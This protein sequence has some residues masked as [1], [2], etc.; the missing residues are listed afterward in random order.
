MRCFGCCTSLPTERPASSSRPLA[1]KL[2]STLRFAPGVGVCSSGACG[3]R[4]VWR[5]RKPLPCALRSSATPA[6][7]GRATDLE[8]HL[9][10]PGLC[11]SLRW[12][13]SF[14]WV[15]FLFLLVRSLLVV[16]LQL[17]FLY[18]PIFSQVPFP[19]AT[20]VWTKPWPTTPTCPTRRRRCQDTEIL[21]GPR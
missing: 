11:L 2:M 6:R 17:V 13:L 19:C 18:K 14:F 12:M 5:A 7:V 8:P 21:Q 3:L 10:G 16:S 15:Y 1:R 4:L 9:L 20:H